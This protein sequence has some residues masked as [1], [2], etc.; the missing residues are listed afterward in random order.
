MAPPTPMKADELAALCAATAVCC[1]DVNASFIAKKRNGQHPTK[2]ASEGKEVMECHNSVKADL[3]AGP[4]AELYAEHYACVKKAGW[5]ES[6]KACRF[7]Q[8]KVAECA[9]RE[10]LGEL[11]QKS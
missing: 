5:T 1:A 4:C 6:V 11:K 3:M 8:A 7:S 10:G 9:V 2:S